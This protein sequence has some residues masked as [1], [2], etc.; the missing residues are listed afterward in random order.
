M[1][2]FDLYIEKV[3]K[4]WSVV[5]KP[6]AVCKYRLMKTA[7]Y[8]SYLIPQ[9]TPIGRFITPRKDGFSNHLSYPYNQ[10]LNFPFIY[11]FDGSL[12]NLRITN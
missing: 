4:D 8:F 10:P 5:S 3:L 9:F 6:P 7:R 2:P 11:A 12:A 1:D